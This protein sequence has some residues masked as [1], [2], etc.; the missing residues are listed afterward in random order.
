MIMHICSRLVGAYASRENV[1]IGI[2]NV[3]T[4]GTRESKQE[5]TQTN[6]FTWPFSFL[7]SG[8]ALFMKD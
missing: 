6:T 1:Y 4:R 3:S 5:E 7:V 8:D 2:F